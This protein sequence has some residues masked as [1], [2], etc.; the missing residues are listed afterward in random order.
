MFHRG[1]NGV[2]MAKIVYAVA[3]EGFGHASRAHL[4]GQRFLD[5]G[6]E[7]IFAARSG[8][9]NTCGRTMATGSRKSSVF[10]RLQQRLCCSG[11]DRLEESL[12][13]SAGPSPQSHAFRAGVPAVRAGFGGY[14]FRAVQR[15]WAWRHRVPF[16]SIDNEH[17][18]ILCQLDHKLSDLF[19][20]LSAAVV[21]RGHYFG[22]RAYIVTSF[23]K[24]RQVQR[25]RP[26]A[27][28]RTARYCP[29]P[30]LRCRAYRGLRHDG[31]PRGTMA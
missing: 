8:P 23:F 11:S 24:P 19:G 30:T 25:S 9:C 29:A 26:G 5:A 18:L 20:R 15:W 28:D 2:L 7:V 10:L 27:A 3:G 16:I 31:H 1:S 17:L 4:I 21:V 12:A 22:A 13:V 14:R 6:H